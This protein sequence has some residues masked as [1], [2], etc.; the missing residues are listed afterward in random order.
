L[1][2]AHPVCYTGSDEFLY[3]GLVRKSRGT[4]YFLLG[5]VAAFSCTRRQGQKILA[6]LGQPE[7]RIY[8]FLR[9]FKTIPLCDPQRFRELLLFL[10]YV[11]NGKTEHQVVFIPCPVNT[12]PADLAEVN[13]S[14]IEH[15]S[16]S[17]EKELVSA[18]EY[19]KTDTLN[20]LF[21]GLESDGNGIPP[22]AL[23]AERAYKNIFIFS[24]G[25]VSRAAMRGGLDYDT[26]IAL[27]DYYLRQ[28]EKVEG[29]AAIFL[30]LKQMFLDFA[31]RTARIRKLETAS[32]LVRKINKAIMARLYEKITPTGLSE[33]LSMNCSY[34]CRH[35]K[36]ETGKTISEYI[37]EVKITEARR[38]L[39]SKEL[40]LIQ[41]SVQLG[42]SSQNY[43]QTLFK[44]ITGTSPG[45][46]RNTGRKAPQA[47]T[48]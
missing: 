13:L 24:A 14:F 19:G 23:D 37:N 3:Y 41:I 45:A 29:Y 48:P 12:I 46:Y 26:V 43:F 15:F 6:R 38:L 17:L 16:G 31:Q 20:A 22:V 7:S 8:E 32:P 18:V 1:E 4:E 30:L 36:Q 10:D 42:F 34:L 2:L 9:W 35:F 5:P 33:I 28:I 40:P 27:S 39:E 47:E 44:R 25:V 21:D 11:V